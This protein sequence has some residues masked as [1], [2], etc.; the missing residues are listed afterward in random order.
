MTTCKP[1][2]FPYPPRNFVANPPA[3]PVYRYVHTRITSVCD[4]L[5]NFR[6][7]LCGLRLSMERKLRSQSGLYVRCYIYIIMYIYSNMQQ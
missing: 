5:K 1:I 3:H 6:R 7:Q 2:Y 4:F